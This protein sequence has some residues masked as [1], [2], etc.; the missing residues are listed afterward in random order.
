MKKLILLLLIPFFGFSQT[1]IGQ[2]WVNLPTNLKVGDTITYQQY[3]SDLSGL[4]RDIRFIQTDISVDNTKLT[5]IDGPVWNTDW[6]GYSKSNNKWSNYNY[7]SD[8]QQTDPNDL[9]AQYSEGLSGKYTSGGTNWIMR[10][11][12]QAT[13]DIEGILFTQKFRIEETLDY[14]NA[15]KLNWAYSRDLDYI[16]LT[17]LYGNPHLL[18]IGGNVAGA[19]AG[20]VTFQLQTPNSVN[21]ESY[22]IIIFDK[23]TENDYDNDGVVDEIYP[24]GASILEGSLDAS[25]KFTTT[26]L[27]QGVKYWVDLYIKSEYD[28]TSQK[29]VHPQW[30][31]DVVT[32]SDVF[33]TFKQALGGGID[34]SEDIF[35][36]DIQELLSDVSY[37][38][39]ES[40][41]QGVKQVDLDDSNIMLA[42]LIGVLENSANDPTLGPDSPFYPITSFNNGSFNYSGLLDYYGKNDNHRGSWHEQHIFEINSSEPTTID[43]AHGLWGDS[44]LS[45][46]TTPTLDETTEIVRTTYSKM[47]SKVSSLNSMIDLDLDV[48][49]EIVDGKVV[50]T[51]N[52][53]KQDLS[54]MQFNISFDSERVDLENVIFDTGNDLTNFAKRLDETRLNFGSIDPRGQSVIKTGVPF[55]LIFTPKVTLQNTIGLVTFRVT[56][57]VQ[58][59][60]KKVNLK[61]Q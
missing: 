11:S 28:Q 57:A 20:T 10:H 23:F 9:D 52:L 35:E 46:S 60:G 53:T 21:A 38:M 29:S 48:L 12:L 33:L 22:Q 56:D 45:H 58:S 31:D 27:K 34:G 5:P 17:D 16:A 3:I 14:E 59:D 55:K 13:A 18:S 6:D 42:H 26:Q 8:Y 2:E 39:A 44:D 40:N 43:V 24:E 51:V 1:E 54:G 36:Y 50:L 61:L 4:N 19:T 25:G 15:I 7:N 30:L 32:V 47:S 37:D 41:Q 49:T